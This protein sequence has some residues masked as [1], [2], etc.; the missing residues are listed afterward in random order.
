M[1][2]R[3]RGRSRDREIERSRERNGMC[4]FKKLTHVACNSIDPC[5][6]RRVDVL[7]GRKGKPVVLPALLWATSPYRRPNSELRHLHES[8]LFSSPNATVVCV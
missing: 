2:S 3:E 4:F 6:K 1:P 7:R 8:I 5:S